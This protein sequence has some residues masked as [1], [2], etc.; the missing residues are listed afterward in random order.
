MPQDVIIIGSGI[1][2]LTAG[3]LLARYGYNVLI[4]E[5]HAIPGGAAHSFT[6]QGFTFDS[7]PSFYAGIGSGKQSLNPL[8][9]VLSL[10][11]E[12]IETVSYDPLGDFHF[13]EGPFAAYQDNDQYCREIA[14]MTPQ[15]ASE[16]QAFLREML[17]LYAGLKDIPTI[18][19]RPDWKIL[20]V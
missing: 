6:R 3:S 17:G 18:E 13:P 11:G 14:K 16:Y 2:G 12:S 15:G 10:L 4:C 9:Q 7:G 20:Q 19:L 1:G 5:S 8:Q